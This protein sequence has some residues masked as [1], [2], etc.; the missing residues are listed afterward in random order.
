MIEWPTDSRKSL[1][2]F[3]VKQCVHLHSKSRSEVDYG[4]TENSRPTRSTVCQTDPKIGQDE[5][6]S[7]DEFSHRDSVLVSCE[8]CESCL[9]FLVLSQSGRS[10]RRTALLRA[11]V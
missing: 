1:K 10:H 5:Q 11:S 3:N 8:S 2:G 4:G 9:I 7:Q 6:D